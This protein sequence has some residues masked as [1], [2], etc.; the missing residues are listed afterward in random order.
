M[1]TAADRGERS[2]GRLPRNLSLGAPVQA[3]RG[4]LTLGQARYTFHKPTAAV[5]G[6]GGVRLHDL[7]H[8][9]ASLVIRSGASIKVVQKLLGHKSAD[10]TV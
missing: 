5:D 2:L 1:T 7:Q 3:R 6:R 8:T 9:C 4:Y 10:L